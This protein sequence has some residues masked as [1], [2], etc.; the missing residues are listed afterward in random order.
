MERIKR[1]YLKGHY[2]CAFA[3]GMVFSIICFIVW[4]FTNPIIFIIVTLSAFIW[5]DKLENWETRDLK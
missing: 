2:Y 4:K 5:I 3:T 1:T